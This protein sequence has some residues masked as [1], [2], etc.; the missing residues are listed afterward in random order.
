MTDHEKLQKVAPEEERLEGESPRQQSHERDGMMT[1]GE[2]VHESAIFQ[3]KLMVDGLR[4]LVLVPVS[5]VATLVGLLRGGDEPAREFN[6]VIML[7]RQ[8]EQWI[9]LFG[10]HATPEDA[11]VATSIDSLLTHV[12]EVVRQQYKSSAIS[13]RARKEIDQA[14]HTVH[15]KVLEKRSGL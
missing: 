7:G 5:L 1:R 11:N 9:N 6:Q 2:L 12:E 4:D 15:E 14:L 3:L 13:D 8:T 10:H